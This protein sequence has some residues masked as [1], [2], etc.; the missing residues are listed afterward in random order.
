MFTCEHHLPIDIGWT[1][2]YRAND[3]PVTY[4]EIFAPTIGLFYPYPIYRRA[5]GDNLFL[6]ILP[7]V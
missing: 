7:I 2:D 6:E 5:S 4:M 1:D 3:L